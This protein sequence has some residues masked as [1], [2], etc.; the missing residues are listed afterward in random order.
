MDELNYDAVLGTPVA[1]LKAPTFVR[2]PQM[3]Q[4]ISNFARNMEAELIN[5]KYSD[6]DSDVSVRVPTKKKHKAMYNY[7]NI[8]KFK[9]YDILVLT[10]LFLLLNTNLTIQ[11]FNDNLK[12]MKSIDINYLNLGLRSVVFGILFYVVKKFMN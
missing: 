5:N 7:F 9:D 11:F 10:L 12:N 1:K 6:S 3:K 2:K 4:N 8:S